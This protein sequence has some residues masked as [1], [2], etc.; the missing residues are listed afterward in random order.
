MTRICS[1]LVSLTAVLRFPRVARVAQ[2]APL[3]ALVACM[4]EPTAYDIE[5]DRKASALSTRSSVTFW[6]NGEIPVCFSPGYAFNVP[7]HAGF[8]ERI[9]AAQ[10][11][12]ESEIET[13]P[14]TQINFIGWETCPNDVEDMPDNMVR[15]VLNKKTGGGNSSIGYRSTG[16]NHAYLYT[17][18]YDMGAEWDTLVLH[19]MTHVLG[20]R[21]EYDRLD[22]PVD[23]CE[24]E[25]PEHPAT[26]GKELT[27]YDHD[28][29]TNKTYCGSET[30]NS[31]SSKLGR[32][33]AMD[34]LGI[35]MAYYDGNGLQPVAAKHGLLVDDGVLTH[36]DD[37]I[38]T[39][40][41]KRGAAPDAFPDLVSWHIVG[42]SPY[43][44]IGFPADRLEPGVPTLLQGEFEDFLG[45]AHAAFGSVVVDNARYAALVHAM[46]AM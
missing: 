35:E 32:L 27:V 19:E 6:P 21:H 40:W 38:V 36:D 45:R 13:I 24:P 2:V 14:N 16:D 20:F 43:V 30:M 37:D 46:V 12:I 1:L 42:E 7:T 44:D 33:T 10:A 3:L 34:K 41:S 5:L 25:D 23:D 28:S 18:S 8:M 4:S 26:D 9:A 22:A 17:E 39:N 31:A 11:V 15:F 29:I